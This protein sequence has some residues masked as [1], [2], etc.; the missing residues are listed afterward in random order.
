[1]PSEK[2]DNVYFGL[3][4]LINGQIHC[5]KSEGV[6]EPLETMDCLHWIYRLAWHKSSTTTYV[7]WTC[8]PRL[9][10]LIC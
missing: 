7:T 8:R 10:Y 1:M 3:F 6:H 4:N 9:E 5:A 2:I